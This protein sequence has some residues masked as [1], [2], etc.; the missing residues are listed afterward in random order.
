MAFDSSVS[1]DGKWV[2]YVSGVSGNNDIYLQSTTG[3]LFTYDVRDFS[4]R[5][6]RR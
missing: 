5:P 6:V 1:P 4:K 2:V 3:V